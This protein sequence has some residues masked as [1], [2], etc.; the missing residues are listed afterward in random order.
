MSDLG[1]PDKP[2]AVQ[3]LFMERAKSFRAIENEDEMGQMV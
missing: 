3:S 2:K 1:T